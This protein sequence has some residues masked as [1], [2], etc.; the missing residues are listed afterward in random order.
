MEDNLNNFNNVELE[1]LLKLADMPEFHVLQKLHQTILNELKELNF[2]K[3]AITDEDRIIHAERV[4]HQ[5]AWD[6]DKDLKKIVTNF[7]SLKSK[8]EQEV[9]R[10]LKKGSTP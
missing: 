5:L 6:R 1:M 3:V 9:S 2:R 8:H 10:K 7:I 4:G